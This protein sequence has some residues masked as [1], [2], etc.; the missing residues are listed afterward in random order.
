VVELGLLL[1]AAAAVFAGHRVH[2][3]AERTGR[4]ESQSVGGD[5]MAGVLGYTGAAVA[6]LLGLLL[7]FAVNDFTA[8]SASATQEA[9]YAGSAF[10]SAADLP[11][12]SAREVQRDLVC[13]IRSTATDSW[14]AAASMDA[15]EAANTLEWRSRTLQ[16]LAAIPKGT[17]EA[18]AT[19]DA[20]RGDIV[21]MTNLS[22]ERLLLAPSD[23]PALMWVVLAI[24]IFCLL[25]PLAFMLDRNPVLW[26]I[27]IATTVLV[28]GAIVAALTFF[29]EP[30]D[31]TGGVAVTPVALQSVEKRLQAQYPS[32]DWSACPDLSLG[33]GAD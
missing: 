32:V 11:E 19:V 27:G 25:F 17:A 18:Q 5:G 29:S 28:T 31:T 30:Y 24:G 2:Q 7:V 6:F 16:D 3:W 13:L 14:E 4:T 20:V 21:A 12:A 10:D 1:V 8:A 26:G 22:Q 9:V 23:L 33:G 15:M